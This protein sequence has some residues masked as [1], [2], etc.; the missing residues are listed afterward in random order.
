MASLAEEVLRRIRTVLP[1]PRRRYALHEPALSGNELEYVGEFIRTGWV[2]S[3][4]GFVDRIEADVAE[5][6][7]A[8]TRRF[9]L[10]VESASDQRDDDEAGD[11]GAT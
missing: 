4:G 6:T 5:E 7:G 8:V 10:D 11:R 2:S 9:F 1:D 3:A